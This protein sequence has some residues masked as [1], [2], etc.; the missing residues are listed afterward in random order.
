MKNNF[1]LS[2][3]ATIL[4]PLSS[5]NH[6]KHPMVCF[7]SSLVNMKRAVASSLAVEIN[8]NIK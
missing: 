2:S 3:N 8:R 5:R 7:P 6:L 1:F 4:E